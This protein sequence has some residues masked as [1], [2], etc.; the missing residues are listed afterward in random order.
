MHIHTHD[1]ALKAHILLAIPTKLA[2]ATPDARATYDA[3]TN[4][5]P[6][7]PRAQ[8]SNLASRLYAQNVR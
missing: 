5:Q 2:L 7:H 3:I 6:G 1:L 4:L 8:S